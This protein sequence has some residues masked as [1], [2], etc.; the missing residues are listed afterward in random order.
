M[1]EKWLYQDEGGERL[2]EFSL[3][4]AP[5]LGWTVTMV[6]PEPGPCRDYILTAIDADRKVLTLRH[7]K[8]SY[9]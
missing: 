9:Q 2:A 3:K 1:T 8:G 5:P 6:G 4:E 7:D